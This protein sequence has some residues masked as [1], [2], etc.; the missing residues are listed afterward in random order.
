MKYLFKYVITFT[1][2]DADLRDYFI[3][4]YPNFKIDGGLAISATN[5]PEPFVIEVAKRLNE[6][7]PYIIFMVR[8]Y[9]LTGSIEVWA[10]QF[11]QGKIIDRTIRKRVY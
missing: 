11:V 8:K 5:L 2:F 4:K 7:F 9:P 1:P 3:K 6:E 10:K